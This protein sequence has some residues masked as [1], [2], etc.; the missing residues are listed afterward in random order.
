MKRTG[1]KDKYVKPLHKTTKHQYS[2][3]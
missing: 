2:I 3:N 1:I